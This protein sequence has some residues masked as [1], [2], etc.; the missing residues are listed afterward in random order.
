MTRPIC[1]LTL[2]AAVVDHVAARAFLQGLFLAGARASTCRTVIANALFLH[3]VERAR[4]QLAIFEFFA[5]AR[6]LGQL[7]DA[8][9]QTARLSAV[10][11][12]QLLA[13]LGVGDAS[14]L[15]HK[16]VVGDDLPVQQLQPNNVSTC[17]RKK[18]R[19]NEPDFRA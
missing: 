3:R 16:T 7:H 12:G 5:E 13:L 9:V 19:S 17:R 18:Q 8:V 14:R 11:G 4:P 10:G 1:F 15:K 6:Q 2:A